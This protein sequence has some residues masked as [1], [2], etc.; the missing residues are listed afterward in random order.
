MKT[1]LFLALV[2]LVGC[3][4]DEKATG[5]PAC[6]AYVAKYQACLAKMAPATKAQ[7]EPPFR[8][9]VASFREAAEDPA[10]R[11]TLPLECEMASRAAAA[12][13]P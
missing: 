4:K 2:A 7:R 3:S 12:E 13:C 10:R 1:A 11:G 8:A 6:D 9:Q 5:V